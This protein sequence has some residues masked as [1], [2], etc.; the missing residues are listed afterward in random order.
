L[1]FIDALLYIQ[2]LQANLLSVL[3]EQHDENNFSHI[4]PVGNNQN[5]CLIELSLKEKNFVKMHNKGNNCEGEVK[6][7]LF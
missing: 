2:M 5:E 7:V 3:R 1:C 6:I 4:T